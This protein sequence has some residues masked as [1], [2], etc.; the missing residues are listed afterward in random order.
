MNKNI[1][2]CYLLFCFS[3]IIANAACT[4]SFTY[5]ITGTAVD[6]TSTADG[7]GADIVSYDWSFGDGATSTL[8]NPEHIYIVS[9]IYPVCLTIVTSDA[10]T[11][12]FCEI[13]N[14]I[15]PVDTINC[16]ADFSFEAI[17]LNV[18]FTNLSD[19]DVG[20]I[21]SYSWDFGDGSYSSDENPEH[22]FTASGYFEVCLTIGTDA[23]C[24]DETCMIIN[25]TTPVSIEN[26]NQ[27]DFNLS[28]NPA[29]GNIE[30]SFALNSNSITNIYLTDISGKNILNIFSGELTAGNHLLKKNISALPAGIYFIYISSENGSAVQKLIKY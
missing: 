19:P 1:N 6:F 4:S 2:C 3:T 14:V 18:S 22:I 9:G 15:N 13:L 16:V 10:C 26:I 30:I 24:S 8:E 28:P 20:A 5:V 29:S 25:V 17:D 21:T 27:F 12:T 7:G 23:G 11:N